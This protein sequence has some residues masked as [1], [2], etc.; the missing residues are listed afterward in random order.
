MGSRDDVHWRQLAP[1]PLDITMRTASLVALLAIS[2]VLVALEIVLWDGVR[3]V[4][5]I[6]VWV[7]VVFRG[8]R[9]GLCIS[10]IGL[11]DR[12]LL[13]TRT[14]AWHEIAG[15]EVRPEGF[16]IAGGSLWVVPHHSVPVRTSLFYQHLRL[17]R[18]Y[19]NEADVVAAM[20]EIQYAL[21]WSRN[22]GV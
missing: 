1:L 18:W 20:H 2:T 3:G 15:V 4:A 6:L 11:R 21:A 7:A 14:F 5:F 16:F 22:R 17:A 9:V 12:S 13:R 10:E 19:R 8:R